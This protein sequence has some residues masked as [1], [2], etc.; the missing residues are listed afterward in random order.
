MVKDDLNQLARRTRR[1]WFTDGLAELVAGLIFI[2]LGIYF[3]LQVILPPDSLLANLLQ[4]GLVLILVGIVFI[5]KRVL[6][7]LKDRL[8]VPRTG[9]VEYS[10]PDKK[11]RYISGILAAVMAALVAGLI[12]SSPAV[13]DWLPALT[14]LIVAAVWIVTAARVGIFRFY[15]IAVASFVLGLVFSLAGLG[16]IL[17]I[18]YFYASTGLLLLISGGIVLLRYLRSNP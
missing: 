3:Y 6:Q 12:L 2:L 7:L 13:Q 17:G 16:D 5:G 4:A 14:G 8:T 15:L 11:H 9:Y 10:S 1:Y 18:A